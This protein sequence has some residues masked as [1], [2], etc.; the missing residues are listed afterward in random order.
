MTRLHFLPILTVSL[1]KTRKCS[2][3]RGQRPDRVFLCMSAR[4]GL[5][6]RKQ[7]CS[8]PPTHPPANGGM[9]PVSLFKSRVQRIQTQ[10][11]AAREVSSAARVNGA[12]FVG[13]NSVACACFYPN[14]TYKKSTERRK[15]RVKT[16]FNPEGLKWLHHYFH[17]ESS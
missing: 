7:E 15:I 2:A 9:A 11:N 1:S 13:C 8:Q 4:Q 12:E 3:E 17:T 10:R 5:E 16:H 14:Y 6:K